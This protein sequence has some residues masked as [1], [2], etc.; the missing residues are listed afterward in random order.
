MFAL[1][2]KEQTSQSCVGLSF[3]IIMRWGGDN[4]DTQLSDSIVSVDR[5]SAYV[6][7]EYC[8]TTLSFPEADVSYRH[9][10]TL[11]IMSILRSTTLQN[12]KPKDQ[13]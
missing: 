1:K 9:T 11:Q 12:S 4:M 8:K 10:N 13:K 2:S 3:S 7:A 5:I 6:V